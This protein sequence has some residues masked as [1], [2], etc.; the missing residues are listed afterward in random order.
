MSSERSFSFDERRLAEEEL[1]LLEE[2]DRRESSDPLR[3]FQP[4]AK[5]KLFIDSVLGK[6]KLENWF[7]GANRSGKSDVGAVCGSHLARFGLGWDHE[8][9]VYSGGI[10]VKDRATS[11]WVS[12]LDFP[13]SRDVMQPKYFNNGFVP[14][15][16]HE[17]FIPQHEIEEWRVS[18]QI[19]RLKNGSIIGFKSADSGRSK[20]Q[21][22]E[23]DW[24]HEDEEHPESIH[25]E[26]TIRVGT[27]PLRI[28]GTCTLLPPEG[29]LG[30]VSWLFPKVIQPFQNGTLDH[31]IGLFGASIYDNP[32]IARSEIERLERRYPEGSIQR[33][34]R[35]N[36]EWLPGLSGARAYVNFQRLIHVRKQPEIN[37]RRPLAWIWDFNVEPMCSI[38]GQKDGD[39]F[40]VHGEFVLD[41]GNTQEMCQLFYDRHPKHYSEIWIYGDATGRKRDTRSSHMTDYSIILNEMRHY[42]VP[43]R[44]KVPEGNPPVPDRINAVNQALRGEGGEVH[45]EVDP[46]CSE[47]IADLE[48]VLRDNRG[49]L[50][51]TYDRKD[52]YYRRTHTSD[53]LGYWINYE[54]P[55][56]QIGAGRK[57]KASIRSP[58]YQKG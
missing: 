10:G 42:G 31:D 17:P 19:L 7:I 25:E 38:V 41:E 26:A 22:A 50:K 8:R 57:H 11:G 53:G 12:C 16:Q 51:K 48:Q 1:F 32:G 55:V 30:G 14:A 44:M 23:K 28:F 24:F 54:A 27:R 13:T 49:G 36:G 40:R 6:V 56:R 52:P 3:V 34:I 45:L 2:L 21:G 46:S 33:R 43:L 9:W 37:L 5:Q 35:L 20:Y 58:G 39:L 15:G 4:H 29:Q 47:L 18:D